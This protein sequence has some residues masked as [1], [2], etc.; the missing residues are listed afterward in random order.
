MTSCA[1][2]AQAPGTTAN[3]DGTPTS[4]AQVIANGG[5][6]SSGGV[7]TVSGTIGAVDAEPLQPSTG[8]IYAITGGF[9]H[10]EP[11]APQ[12]DPLFANGF[13]GL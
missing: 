1:A 12:A 5:G 11:V 3:P 13:E 10:T 7:Y 4:N 2:N 8:G 6:T 9:W